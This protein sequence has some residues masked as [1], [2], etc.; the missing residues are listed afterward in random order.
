VPPPQ[1]PP[2]EPIHI[3]PGGAAQSQLRRE[4][5]ATAP[6][7]PPIAPPLPEPVADAPPALLV[8]DDEEGVRRALVQLGRHYGLHVDTAATGEDGLQFHRDRFQARRR[9]DIILVDI[10]LHGSLNGIEVFH[11]IR[12]IDPEAAI[13]ATSGICSEADVERYTALGFSGFLPKP[14]QVEDFDEMV[15]TLLAPAAD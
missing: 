2:A 1:H 10:N 7:V 15:A 13:V 9:Y 12:R 8:I 4:P 6:L 11:A 14:F 3:Y 5:P